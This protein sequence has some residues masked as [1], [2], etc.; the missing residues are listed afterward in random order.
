MKNIDQINSEFRI[1]AAFVNQHW[2]YQGQELKQYWLWSAW[3]DVGDLYME[4]Q[5]PTYAEIR[6]SIVDQ[7]NTILAKRAH[8]KNKEKKPF[9]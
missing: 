9:N 8:I 1:V 6:K 4:L 5:K 2:W 3:T 7:Y